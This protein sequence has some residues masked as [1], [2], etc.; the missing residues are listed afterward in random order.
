MKVITYSS[1]NDSI[2]LTSSQIR[3]LKKERVCPKDRYGMEYCLT[4]RESHHGRPTFTKKQ[5][6]MIIDGENAGDL[7]ADLTELAA[8]VSV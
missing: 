8:A 1:N 7:K 5:I 4:S 3:A 2:D 6:Q